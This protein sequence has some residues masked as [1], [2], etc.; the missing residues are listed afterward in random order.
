MRISTLGLLFAC[1]FAVFLFGCKKA[2]DNRPARVRATVTVT[3]RGAPVEGATVTL[4]PSTP[5]GKPAFGRTDAQGRAVLGTFDT[6]DGA[7]PG[8]YG[9]TVVKMEGGQQGGET[10]P[11][12]IGAMPANTPGGPPVPQTS[13]PKHLLPAKYA[14]VNTSGLRFTVSPTGDNNFTADLQD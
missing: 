12:E 1:S 13:G 5:D 11:T 10:A 14:D 4:H 6:G 2:A 9:V 7:I 3:Y 8:D